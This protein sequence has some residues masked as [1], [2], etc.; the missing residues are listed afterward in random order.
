ME[1]IARN[2]INFLLS[3]KAVKKW[4][5]SEE[6]EDLFFSCICVPAVIENV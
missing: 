4:E 6:K 1:R 5:H 3:V 2:Y